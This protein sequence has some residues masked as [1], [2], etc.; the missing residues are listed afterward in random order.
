MRRCLAGP[1]ILRPTL[2]VQ[3]RQV[4]VT[5]SPNFAD[6]KVSTTMPGMNDEDRSHLLDLYDTNP[7]S[8]EQFRSLLRR[9]IE[10]LEL[11]P[12]EQEIMHWDANGRNPDELNRIAKNAWDFQELG[13]AASRRRLFAGFVTNSDITNG[14]GADYLIDWALRAGIPADAIYNAMTISEG[15]SN[16]F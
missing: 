4:Y 1:R 11:T 2:Q 16:Q 6:A 10:H 9:L 3:N 15:R 13:N 8:V 7:A 5:T 12:E 14:Y